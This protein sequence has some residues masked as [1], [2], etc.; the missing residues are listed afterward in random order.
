MKRQISIFAVFLFASIL[1]FGGCIELKH[2]PDNNPPLLNNVF[3][4]GKGN[5]SKI[6]NAID[7]ASDNDT[8]FVHSGTY[9]E[10]IDVYKSIELIGVGRDTTIIDGNKSGDV[11]HISA[12][13]IKISG[14][15]IQNGGDGIYDA[16]VYVHSSNIDINNNLILNSS[17]GIYL[18]RE[19]KKNN[20]SNNIILNNQNGL[21][22][23]SSIYNNI[24]FNHITNN[25]HYGLYVR[26]N[27]NYNVIWKNTFSHNKDG[28]RIKASKYNEVFE[29]NIINNYDKGI[30]VC[31]SSNNNLYYKNSI[32]ENEINAQDSY[33]NQWNFNYVGNY[34]GDYKEK[35]PDAKDA[36]G[37][38]IWDTPYEISGG[39]NLDEFP[40]TEPYS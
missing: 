4:Y 36:D 25:T 12:N 7:N 38:G 15:T 28:M 21:Y 22:L 29:N 34:W 27:S 1:S 32:F 11:I 20:V 6:Q 37:D 17:H 19:T 3:I 40:L 23:I 39:N 18:D 30:Y 2:N 24:S 16:G 33:S 8:I 35:H 10:N 9:Y 13:W 26:D 5:Y 14:F 31:C